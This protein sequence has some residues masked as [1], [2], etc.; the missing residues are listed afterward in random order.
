MD[1]TVHIGAVHDGSY[2][3][4]DSI[5]GLS[6]RIIGNPGGTPPHLKVFPAGGKLSRFAW[7]CEDLCNGIAQSCLLESECSTKYFSYVSLTFS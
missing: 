2:D 4:F 3:S 6:S 1:R 5:Y 7:F